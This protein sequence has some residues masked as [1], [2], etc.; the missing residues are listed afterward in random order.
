MSSTK[1]TWD[2]FRPRDLP[3]YPWFPCPLCKS[4]GYPN[5][6]ESCDH[7]RWERARAALPGLHMPLVPSEKGKE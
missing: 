4:E 2:G 5:A 3:G 1:T 6:V 7:T